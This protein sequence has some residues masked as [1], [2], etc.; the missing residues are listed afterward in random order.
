MAPCDKSQAIAAIR[1]V[2]YIV[3][4]LIPACLPALG[5]NRKEPEPP[6]EVK[7]EAVDPEKTPI[8]EMVKVEIED[9][10]EVDPPKP[11]ASPQK[12]PA[13]SGERKE[14]EK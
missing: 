13:P 10:Q 1:A 2:S 3:V 7:N 12:T 9:L 11:N 14:K 4:I 5:C 6:P 8:E